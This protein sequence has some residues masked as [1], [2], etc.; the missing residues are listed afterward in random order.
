M[1]E[2]KACPIDGH[3][4]GRGSNLI[5]AKRKGP[6][7]ARIGRL[8]RATMHHKYLHIDIHPQRVTLMSRLSTPTDTDTDTAAV[9]AVPPLPPPPPN[10]K[11]KQI[12]AAVCVR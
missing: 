10:R 6:Q 11:K 1:T 9:A 5:A 4:G 12:L 8:T 7:D 2:K 3:Y